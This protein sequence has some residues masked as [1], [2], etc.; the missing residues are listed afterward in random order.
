MT[1]TGY[2]PGTPVF[3]SLY[4]GPGHTTSDLLIYHCDGANWGTYAA[5][6]LS[7]D[8]NYANFTVTDFSGYAV[9]T[10][11]TPE[12]ASLGLLAAGLG[13]LLLRRRRAGLGSFQGGS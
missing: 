12:P 4:V 13:G 8:G 5:T 9:V 1:P 3:L 11:L 6:D 10:A 7:Y 2:I